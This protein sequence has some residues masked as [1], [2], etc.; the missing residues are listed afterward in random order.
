MGAL[1]ILLGL[2]L[3]I[4]NF[5]S[6]L[7]GNVINE[8]VENSEGVFFLESNDSRLVEAQQQ[9][10]NEINYFIDSLNKNPAYTYGI[11]AYFEDEE[12][13]EHMWL[14]VDSYS[15]GKFDSTLAS[16]P[17]FVINY[18]E[19]DKIIVSKEDIEDWAILDEN[20]NVLYGDFLTKIMEKE[21]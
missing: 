7:T 15:N 8:K 18:Q 11:K 1:F 20:S 17:E 12:H 4:I 13:G 5:T 16:K 21:A 3:F 2:G 10:Q 14:F 19:G 6:D 9:A